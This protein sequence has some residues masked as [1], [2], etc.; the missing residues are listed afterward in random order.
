MRVDGPNWAT[1]S[2]A[3]NAVGSASKTV[4]AIGVVVGVGMAA[5]NI[6]SAPEGQRGQVIAGEAGTL[7]GGLAGGYGG[8]WLGG[9]IGTLFAPGPGTAIGAF[10]GSLG[11]GAG[12][13]VLGEKAATEV[14]KKVEDQ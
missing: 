11:G 3:W 4:G 10:L 13:A 7:G 2:G 6:A 14:Y 9:A 8:A 5:S 1:T 12:G